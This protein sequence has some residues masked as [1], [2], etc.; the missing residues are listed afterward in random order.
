MFN[1]PLRSD[2]GRISAFYILDLLQSDALYFRDDQ[3]V[4]QGQ[5]HRVLGMQFNS[6]KLDELGDVTQDLTAFARDVRDW[7]YFCQDQSGLFVA[8]Q[9]LSEEARQLLG[10]Q[11]LTAVTLMN[12]LCTNKLKLS[13]HDNLC[14]VA[15]DLQVKNA[16][17]SLG[18]YIHSIIRCAADYDGISQ[19]F[20]IIFATSQ[21]K[22]A[23]S[24]SVRRALVCTAATMSAP[25]ELRKLKAQLQD[26]RELTM[27]QLQQFADDFVLR[28]IFVKQ[29][30]KN[31]VLNFESR[32][33]SIL[34]AEHTA[35]LEAEQ[36]QEVI[37]T[38]VL[39]QATMRYM[40]VKKAI[41]NCT[42][43]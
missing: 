27:E 3:I 12:L 24:L 33:A 37:R 2:A 40:R 1:A 4:L 16:F 43:A 6:E 18:K 31:Y 15:A 42:A 35:A 36:N 38:L 5:K 25:F 29:D 8:A 41:E 21:T 10:G 9:D 22:D 11:A 13:R 17:T 7:M 32:Q 14:L 19:Q 28:G 26:F 23:K 39:K 20:D 34:Y 30:D